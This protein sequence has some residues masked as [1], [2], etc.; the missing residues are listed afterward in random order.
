VLKAGEQR[1]ARWREAA[2]RPSGPSGGSLLAEIREAL[3]HD[4]DTP[5]VL[6]LVDAWCDA[7]LAG[8]GRDASAPALLA[9]SVDALLGVRL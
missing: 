3:A 1:L 4:L 7:A 9:M 2:A 5:R 6:T 8:S